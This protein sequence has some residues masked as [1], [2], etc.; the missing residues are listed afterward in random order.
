MNVAVLTRVGLVAFTL[1]NG[2]IKTEELGDGYADGS[3]GERGA[4]PS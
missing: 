3:E 2:G 4:E 1:G